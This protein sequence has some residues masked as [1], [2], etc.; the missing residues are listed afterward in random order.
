MEG[1]PPMQVFKEHAVA[2]REIPDRIKKYLFTMRYIRVVQRN[3]VVLD[4]AYYHNEN[5]VDYN[6]R[7][8]EAR[9]G[10]DDAGTVHIFSYPDRV[11]LFDAEHLAFS[12]VVQ[13][14]IQKMKKLRKDMKELEKKY[15]RKKEEYDKGVFKTP[16]ET[17]AEETRKVVNGSPVIADEPPAL[18]LVKPAKK[19]I[20]GIFD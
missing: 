19:K 15:N 13:E 4:G 7:K 3:G 18:K 9:R 8:V 14:D 11:Y 6:G 2:R 20:I 5:L 17:Y 16:A 1:R 12:G 10:L